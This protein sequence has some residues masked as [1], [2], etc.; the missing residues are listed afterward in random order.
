[1][2]LT[3]KKTLYLLVCLLVM[4]AVLPI[5]VSAAQS[6][7]TDAQCS[8]TI[9]Y[10]QEELPLTGAR[11]QLYRVAEISENGTLTPTQ[12]FPATVWTTPAWTQPMSRLCWDMPSWMGSNRTGP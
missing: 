7:Q 6:V 1:M 2:R 12:A 9:V 5:S 11:F 10:R 4:T 8:L 3:R